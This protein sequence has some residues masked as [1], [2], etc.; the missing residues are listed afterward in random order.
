MRH[1]A[2]SGLTLSTG[3]DTQTMAADPGPVGSRWAFMDRACSSTSSQVLMLRV[4]GD[5]SACCNLAHLIH[6]CCFVNEYFTTNVLKK[7][8]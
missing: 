5:V 7:T 2:G 6:A 3:S 4:I 8:N 1:S